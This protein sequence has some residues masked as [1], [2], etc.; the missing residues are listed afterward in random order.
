MRV[1]LCGGG[2]A[3]HVMPAVAISE[4][5]EK[6]FPE[7]VIAFAGRSGG[8]ENKAYQDT[9]HALYTVD[10]RG[11]S[12][13]FSINNIK[14]IFKLLKSSRI[15]RRI[16]KDFDPDIIIGTGG[17]VCFP[18][19]RQGQRKGIKTVMHES[20]IF[21]GLVTR[22]LGKRCD[23]LLLNF[24]ASKQYLN[25]QK[26]TVV[27][28]NPL[29]HSFSSLTKS[30]ARER[31][32]IEKDKIFIVSFGGSLGAEV[33][34]DVIISCMKELSNKNGNIK[35]IHSAG[36]A[37][38]EN[39]KSKYPDLCKENT[40]VRIVPYIDDMPI[41][42]TAADL[43]ITRSGAMTIS[44]LCRSSTASILIPSP[45]VTANHQYKNAKHM[46]ILGAAKIIEEKELTADQLINEINAL[47]SSPDLI[48]KMSKKASAAYTKNTDRMVVRVLKEL[49]EDKQ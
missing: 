11:I 7:S 13:S 19:I 25:T 32:G 21:P 8:A 30:Q 1:L 4:I 10:I 41:Y 43:A 6:N 15:A 37:H 35:H 18:F 16:I 40:G 26:N 44:E 24:E 48:R 20:N 34:N 17:Y 27:V 38:F 22:L 14:S 45:N 33:L 9:G 29:R 39:I 5:I 23:R 36:R 31:L 46:E 12:R 42:L 3:G 47:I 2:T 49:I 28:G